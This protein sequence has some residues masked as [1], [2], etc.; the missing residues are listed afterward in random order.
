MIQE[1]LCYLQLN[2][3]KATKKSF[4]C[5]G[6]KIEWLN[7]QIGEQK[8]KKNNVWWYFLFLI[9]N[10]FVFL[11]LNHLFT[12][13]YSVQYAGFP[14]GLLNIVHFCTTDIGSRKYAFQLSLDMLFL[15]NK[16]N[17]L[18]NGKPESQAR[19]LKEK[20][21]ILNTKVKRNNFKLDCDE[22][23]VFLF[24]FWE[25]KNE[26]IRSE[27]RNKYGVGRTM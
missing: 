25:S 13:A 3:N 15:F 5:I 11:F 8:E 23:D 9:T 18:K 4:Q 14:M 19:T 22:D 26:C 16:F 10:F 2:E 27:K 6:A 1:K 21:L 7:I 17:R 24:C 12:D 20:K